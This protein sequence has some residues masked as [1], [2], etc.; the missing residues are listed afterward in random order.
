M[1]ISQRKQ[2]ERTISLNLSITSVLHIVWLSFFFLFF[3]AVG[4]GDSK[5][6]CFL[7]TLS[8]LLLQISLYYNGLFQGSIFG[9]SLYELMALGAISTIMMSKF[10][11][12]NQL[13]I[14]CIAN[15]LFNTYIWMFYFKCSIFLI[16]L[17]WTLSPTQRKCIQVLMP[18]NVILYG[19][20]IA[21]DIISKLERDHNG[22]E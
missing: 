9:Y 2:P 20:R 12:S 7:F 3:F 6:Y 18:K 19:I 15:H 17:G 10:I 14:G 4:E 13:S 22:V 8:C 1:I 21:A 5:R 16:I 11:S